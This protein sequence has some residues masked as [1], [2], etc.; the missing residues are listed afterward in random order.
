VAASAVLPAAA[1]EA[2]PEEALEVLPAAASAKQGHLHNHQRECHR[3]VLGHPGTGACRHIAE[4]GHQTG[5]LL[6]KEEQLLARLLAFQKDPM[7]VEETK[8]KASGPWA[9]PDCQSRHH[10]TYEG[11]L[12]AAACHTHLETLHKDLEAVPLEA[13]PLE[14]VPLEAVPLEVVPLEAD[15]WAAVLRN[16]RIRSPAAADS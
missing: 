1:L 15:S 16:L 11:P 14:A 7:R 12:L 5:C 13:V 4:A 6:V 2:H 3:L 10:L 8:R 9:A